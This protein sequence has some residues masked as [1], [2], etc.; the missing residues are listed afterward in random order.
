MD[1]TETEIKDS[2][3]LNKELMKCHLQIRRTLFLKC[4]MP[5]QFVS[6]RNSDIGDALAIYVEE[7]KLVAGKV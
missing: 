2:K 6:K 5:S 1:E 4:G 3:E 7:V